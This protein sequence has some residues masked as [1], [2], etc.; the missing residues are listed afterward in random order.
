MLVRI[1]E[2]Y[3]PII[4]VD[5]NYAFVR[6]ELG[7]DPFLHDPEWTTLRSQQGPPRPT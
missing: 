1:E 4:Y 5:E 6:W 7:G 2:L 3:N